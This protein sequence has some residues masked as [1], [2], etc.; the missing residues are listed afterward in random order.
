MSNKGQNHKHELKKSFCCRGFF[1]RFIVRL[2]VVGNCR[3]GDGDFVRNAGNGVAFVAVIFNLCAAGNGWSGFKNKAFVWRYNNFAALFN[4]CFAVFLRKTGYR[5]ARDI[6]G[7]FFIL[8]NCSAV[9]VTDTSAEKK[10]RA[11]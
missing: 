7:N 6:N 10:N 1:F 5:S 8:D 11:A 4:P 3:S 9:I 2:W